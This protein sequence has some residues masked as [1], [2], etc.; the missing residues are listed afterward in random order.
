MCDQA[1]R[2]SDAAREVAGLRQDQQRI[3][4]QALTLLDLLISMV[5]P[6]QMDGAASFS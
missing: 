2:K 1:P 6:R 4:K 5:V 3:G